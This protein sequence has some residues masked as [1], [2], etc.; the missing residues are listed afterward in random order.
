[1]AQLIAELL[2]EKFDN[3]EDAMEYIKS[4]PSETI[5]KTAEVLSQYCVSSQLENNS[6]NM[7]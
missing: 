1:M 4:V 6:G 3:E 5:I 2:G 7:D